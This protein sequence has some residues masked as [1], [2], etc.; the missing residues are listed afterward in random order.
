MSKWTTSP[1]CTFWTESWF[2]NKKHNGNTC[3]KIV[4]DIFVKPSCHI[5]RCV[6]LIYSVF[7][8]SLNDLTEPMG[9]FT[10]V[11]VAEQRWFRAVWLCCWAGCQDWDLMPP[12]P[13]DFDWHD[14]HTH[15]PAAVAHIQTQTAESHHFHFEVTAAPW[16]LM[17]CFCSHAEVLLIVPEHKQMH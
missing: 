4:I 1:Q 5:N 2:L 13:L 17:L 9:I 12:K 15:W 16:P 7:Q 8:V 6:Y 3:K 11:G 14:R 10:G